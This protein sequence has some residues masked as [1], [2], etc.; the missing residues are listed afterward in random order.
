MWIVDRF[1]GDH[2]VLEREDGT[3]F[4]LARS[5]LPPTAREGDVLQASKAP[6][7]D[8]ATWRIEHDVSETERRRAELQRQLDELHQR[9]PGGDITL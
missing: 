3:T 4:H 2:A 5:V 1:E 9:D 8:R 6:D 7:T